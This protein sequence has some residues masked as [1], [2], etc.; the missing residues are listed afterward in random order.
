MIKISVALALAVQAAYAVQIAESDSFEW[1]F[2]SSDDDSGDDTGLDVNMS[3][4]TDVNVQSIVQ[5]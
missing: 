4:N 3:D 5:V 2:G 1:V